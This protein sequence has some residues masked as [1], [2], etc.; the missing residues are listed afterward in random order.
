MPDTI[1]IGDPTSPTLYHGYKPNNLPSLLDAIRR[2]S[3]ENTDWNGF[4][5]AETPYHAAEYSH[6]KIQG[7]P[8]TRAGGVVKVSF[9][10]SVK[11]A[12]VDISQGHA[13]H[14]E[15]FQERRIRDIKN[16]FKIP[17]GENLMDALV[18]DQTILKILDDGTGRPEYIIPWG[19]AEKQCHAEPHKSFEQYRNSADEAYAYSAEGARL[20]GCVP[21]GR[22]K[23]SAGSCIPAASWEAIEHR[24][25]EMASAVAR[26]TEYTKSL[27]NR[28]PKGPTWSEAHTTSTSTHARVSAKSGAHVAVGAFAVGSWIY[29][30]SET[31]AN[32]N[33]T[34]LDKAAATV[35][36][37]PGI[38]H[39]LGIAAALEHHDIEGV[40][41][42]AISI[43]ALA[44]AQVVPVVGEIVDAALLAEQLVEV[45]V[46]VFRASTTE[47]P[48]AHLETGVL[49][50]LP[51]PRAWID[52]TAWRGKMEIRWKTD[53]SD[54]DL[55]PG[56]YV[57]AGTRVIVRERGD[58]EYEF[59]MAEGVSPDWEAVRTIGDSRTFDVFYRFELDGGPY[60]FLESEKLAVVRATG[61]FSMIDTT[62]WYEDWTP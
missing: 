8:R 29:G 54:K 7:E 10:K 45:L 5:L 30:L 61:K 16:H 48:A 6:G 58:A 56:E 36:I 34:T 22:A 46:H 49:P 21:G 60:R 13:E 18:K 31:F 37:V 27:P 39:A 19:I 53:R 14:L 47:P 32:N 2:K 33:V 51:A 23:R 4:Y 59:P 20:T 24:S 25:K 26:D 17:S 35:A 41:V 3:S 44:A 40:V 42:N 1:S 38:G 55:P 9:E 28:H 12:I 15:E 43:A 62:A 57:P 11:I 52:A 50:V